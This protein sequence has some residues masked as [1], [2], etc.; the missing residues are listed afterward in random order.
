MR[1]SVVSIVARLCVFVALSLA[2]ASAGRAAAPDCTGKDRGGGECLKSKYGEVL[3]KQEQMKPKL[4]DLPCFKDHPDRQ[5]RLQR[6]MARGR[7]AYDRSDDEDFRRLTRMKGKKAGAC[8]FYAEIIGDGVGND[9]GRCTGQE[10]CLEV[11]GDGVGNDDG[12]CDETVEVCEC[13]DE[14]DQTGLGVD[15]EDSLDDTLNALDELDAELDNQ[16]ARMATPAYGTTS[17]TDLTQADYSSLVS[18]TRTSNVLAAVA[19]S[20]VLYMETNYTLVE[21]VCAQDYGGFNVELACVPSQMYYQVAKIVYD[22]L[23]FHDGQI[24]SAEIQGAYLRAGDIWE[25]VGIVQSAVGSD[26]TPDE[27]TLHGKVDSLK[28][29]VGSIGADIGEL[30]KKVAAMQTRLD[31]LEEKLVALK[32]QLEAI[33]AL[34]LSPQGR[35]PG[36]PDK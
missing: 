13:E 31:S 21:H 7:N 2:V 3:D 11:I 15:I 27:T 9:D 22:A 6:A 35:R 19:Q 10:A 33:E 1:I 34:L 23:A 25:R 20:V 17:S 29:S 36:F 16:P 14:Y 4:M 32:G 8:P 5:E 26:S 28:G 18:S 24:D 12:V 30:D